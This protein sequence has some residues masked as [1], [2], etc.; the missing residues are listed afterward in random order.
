MKAVFLSAL[1]L[2]GVS[3]NA[4]P[5]TAQGQDDWDPRRVYMTREALEGLLSRL[6]AASRST[7]YTASLKRRGSFEAALIRTRL[8]QGDFQ[9]GDRILLTVEDEEALSDTFTVAQGQVLRLETIGEVPLRGV[10]RAEL[11]P[12]VTKFLAEYLREPVVTARSLIPI[13]IHGGVGQPGFYTVPSE[14]LLPAA[15][16]L[17]GGFA[18]DAEITEVRV[19]RG[20]SR[21]W[22]AEAL[23]QAI[24]EGRTLDQL[25]MRGGDRIFVPQRSGGLGGAESGLRAISLLMAIP[26]TIVGLIAIF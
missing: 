21:I 5:L 23:Q 13:T 26:L 2:M 17:A 3:L 11:E 1:V 20:D 22:E 24:V 15:I 6:E 12:H 7:V 25:N 19:E 4:G 10:L 18:Q 16:M 14:A 8:D 9:V